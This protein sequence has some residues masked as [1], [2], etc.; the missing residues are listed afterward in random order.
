MNIAKLSMYAFGVILTSFYIFPVGLPGGNTK[1]YMAIIGILLF[2]YNGAKQGI[3][4]ISKNIILLVVLAAAVSLTSWIAIVINNTNDTTYVTYVFSMLVWLVGAYTLISYLASVHKNINIDI[5]CRYLIIVGVVQSLLAIIIDNFPT[6]ESFF[7]RIHL[8]NAGD[9][10]YAKE[11]DRLFGV[12]CVYDT[13]GIRLAAI[14]V[15]AGF[16]YHKVMIVS[17][18]WVKIAFLASIYVTLIFGSMIS[19][20]TTV[21]FGI[22]AVYILYD[23]GLLRFKIREGYEVPLKWL[24]GSLAV[25][26]VV[27]GVYYT[28]NANFRHNFRFGFEGFVSLVEEGEWNV[29][30]NDRLM[31]MYRFPQTLHTWIIGDGYIDTTDLDPYYTGHRYRGYYMATDVGY[32]RFIYY[33]GLI[34]LGSF[35]TF[36]VWVAYTCGGYFPKYK[37]LFWLLFILQMAIW[38]KVASDIFCMSAV[39]IALGIFT[40]MGAEHS[41]EDIVED[42]EHEIVPG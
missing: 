29:S 2:L 4:G 30:S 25:A 34:M 13:G 38:F 14:L 3:S 37:T 23:S 32:L 36:F 28:A 12:G 21:G 35:I 41:E 8:L 42:G 24:F 5:L 15:I 22:A 9:V 17:K 39:F 33:G 18:T 40:N 11:A 7:L 6:V 10:A 19:R 20:T 16:M 27:V 31:T 1:F 26:A